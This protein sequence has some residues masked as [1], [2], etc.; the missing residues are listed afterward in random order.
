[1][2]PTNN[3]TP[4]PNPAPATGVP[5][6]EPVGSSV[7]G[8]A[9][10]P[11]PT[12]TPTPVSVSTQDTTSTPT[13]APTPAP[14]PASTPVAPVVSTAPVEAPVAPVDSNISPSSMSVSEPAAPTTPQQPTVAEPAM[15]STPISTDA[16][17]DS[18]NQ[19]SGSMPTQ[20]D[21]N[22]NMVDAGGPSTQP[23]PV[24]DNN[25]G[26]SMANPFTGETAGSTPSVSFA[27]PAEQTEPNPM[28]S[29]AVSSGKKKS[30]RTT[31]IILVVVA[32][33]V[34]IALAAV[35]IFQLTS[36]E[37]KNPE[38]P[39]PT[40][41]V[42]N[43]GDEPSDGEDEG[44]DTYNASAVLTCTANQDTLDK[45]S[46][47][48][49]QNIK[50]NT[51]TLNFSDNKLVGV[52]MDFTVVSENGTEINST[53]EFTVSEFFEEAGLSKDE[54]AEQGVKFDEDGNVIVS[55]EQ[56]LGVGLD[57]YTCISPN[58]S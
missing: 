12:S 23:D 41:V 1:M 42:E 53:S 18:A 43:D 24:L 7:P 9:P 52:T 4:T 5:P 6:M 40:P 47:Q 31:L 20:S 25:L 58:Q 35:L 39:E 44:D 32:F 30:S 45:M 10:V 15:P 49:G 33:M 14:A 8:V 17:A 2:D 16:V 11:T 13:Q 55:K 29:G 57:G 56:I 27:D 21:G 34:V 22:G 54:L 36:S 50:S 48:S 26:S 3:P 28:S 19:V 46:S 38:A 51:L 37:Q